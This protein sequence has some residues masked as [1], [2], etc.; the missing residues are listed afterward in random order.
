MYNGDTRLSHAPTLHRKP[1]MRCVSRE[2]YRYI[3]PGAAPSRNPYS[4]RC[5]VEA[6]LSYPQLLHAL[7]H[8]TR[9][10]HGRKIGP[11]VN[12]WQ[13]NLRATRTLHTFLFKSSHIS[14][15][16]DRA[17]ERRGSWRLLCLGVVLRSRIYCIKQ[18]VEPARRFC[19]G[20]FLVRQ[21]S[22]DSCTPRTQLHT[23]STRITRGS[24]RNCLGRISSLATRR[25]PGAVT[26]FPV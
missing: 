16:G 22:Q 13:V 18:S 12:L 20:R 17:D 8:A 25:N 5:S 9:R 15:A 4:Q 11:F 10:A 23:V 1:H 3:R 6:L 21:H 24:R 7:S 14:K 2:I 26:A 19:G